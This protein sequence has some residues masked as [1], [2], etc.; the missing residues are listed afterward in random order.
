MAQ[1]PQEQRPQGARH[2]PVIGDRAVAPRSER[3][4][5]RRFASNR[6]GGFHGGL[7]VTE[8]VGAPSPKQLLF[9]DA[10]SVWDFLFWD[11]HLT[12]MT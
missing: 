12:P 7:G 8:E 10:H 2:G 1:P 6:F 3:P 5:T 4:G 11:T 9:V